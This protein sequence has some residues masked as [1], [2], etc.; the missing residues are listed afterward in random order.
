MA[1]T[2][3]PNKKNAMRKEIFCLKRSGSR[4]KQSLGLQQVPI[5]SIASFYYV[6]KPFIPRYFQII[7]RREIILCKRPLHKHIWPIDPRACKLPERWT[8]WPDQKQFALVLQH[9]VDTRNGE[10]RCYQ[11]IELEESLG[12]RSSFNFVPESYKV[13]HSLR[14]ELT[15]KGFEVGVHGLKHD[16]RLFSSKRLFQER[17]VRINHYLKEWGAAG[18]ASPSMHHRLDWMHDLKISH[19]TST[20]DTDPFEP[21][22]DGV[23]T[24]F[25][26]WVHGNSNQKGYVELPYTLPQDFTLFILM[27]EKSIDIWK[28]KL[29]WIAEKG[30]MALLNVHPDYMNFG[31]NKPSLEEYPAEYYEELLYYI[32]SKYEGQYWHVLSKD[33]ARFWTQLTAN[34]EGL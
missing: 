18:F 23:G 1:T 31:N 25:P 11:L 33:M 34:R 16:G 28:Q 30:G 3:S 17:A 32:K 14:N 7:L 15:S 12:F 21:Q 24:I 6:L 13:P 4:K 5:M 22:S 8:G 2:L 19:A 26:F 9:D 20:F 29:D 10:D 27:K